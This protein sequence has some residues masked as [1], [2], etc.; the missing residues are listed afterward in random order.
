M[1]ME[2]LWVWVKV[3][4]VTHM[5]KRGLFSS[6]ENRQWGRFGFEL[7]V[8]S[9]L[10]TT[11]SP[12]WAASQGKAGLGRGGWKGAWDEGALTLVKSRHHCQFRSLR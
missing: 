4:A 9:L 11:S 7:S 8:A 3:T 5:P 6:P 2:V 12:P 10:S 1:V